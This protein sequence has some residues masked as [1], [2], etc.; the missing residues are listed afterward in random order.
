LRERGERKDVN[1]MDE[2]GKMTKKKGGRKDDWREE[3]ENDNSREDAGKM[4]MIERRDGKQQ[5]ERG[6]MENN[7][8]KRE[9]RER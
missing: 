9:E 1:K 2:I 4:T 8:D 7:D 5:Q 6:E 3:T